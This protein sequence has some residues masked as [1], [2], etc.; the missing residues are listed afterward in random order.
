MVISNRGLAK[1]RQPL[2]FVPIYVKR[3]HYSKSHGIIGNMKRIIVIGCP[4]SGKSTFS[5]A[6]HEKT[7]APLFHLDRMFWKED[8]TTVERSVFLERLTDALEKD[9]WIIDGNYASTMEMRMQACDTVVFLDYSQEV[10]LDG[11]KV[12]KGKRR[13]DL[14]WIEPEDDDREFLAFIKSYNTQQRPKVMELLHAYSHKN[15]YI[16]S[17]RS[18]AEAFLAQL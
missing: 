15:I 3:L 2:K 5:R 13:S 1:D 16:F 11:V 7:G 17:D 18:E 14:P 9:V 8:G 12:R 10:C 6:L 4:G